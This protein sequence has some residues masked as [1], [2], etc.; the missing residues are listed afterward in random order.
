MTPLRCPSLLDIVCTD[1]FIAQKYDFNYLRRYYIFGGIPFGNA[2]V[3]GGG[4]CTSTTC[5]GF[6]PN[7]IQKFTTP[8]QELA[9][10]PVIIEYNPL[11]RT[12]SPVG[13]ELSRE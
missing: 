8:T 10:Y 9:S 7:L 12:S 11:I 13:F 2:K 3:V 1:A 5:S 6:Q 4:T